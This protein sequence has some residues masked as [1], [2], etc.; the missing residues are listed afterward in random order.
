MRD[1]LISEARTS[2]DGGGV[3]LDCDM[4]CVQGVGGEITQVT[5]A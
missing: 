2:V 3:V 4:W 1:L 5:S